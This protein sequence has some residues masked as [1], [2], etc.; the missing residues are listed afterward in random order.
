MSEHLGKY[1]IDGILGKG[2]MGVVYKAF[3]PYIQRVVALKTI[4]KELFGECQMDDLISRLKNE[5]QAA[6]RLNHSNIVMVYDY[7][8]DNELAYIAMEFVEGTT[9]NAMIQAHQ[10]IEIPR[11]KA[12][13]SDLLLALQYA[14]SRGVVH[15]D[16]KPSNL[17]ITSSDRLK[18]S[19]FGVAHL[20]TSTLTEIGSVIGTPSYMSPEQFRGEPL[21]ARSDLFSA[22]IVLYQLL[23]GARPF[24]GSTSA[25]MH[26][27][28]TLTPPPPSHH[29]PSLGNAYDKVVER[30]MAKA[31]DDRYA[32]AIE[33]LRALEAVEDR[34]GPLPADTQPAPVR[35][36]AAAVPERAPDGPGASDPGLLPTGDIDSDS[37]I[38]ADG[39]LTTLAESDRTMLAATPR[40]SPP[41]RQAAPSASVDTGPNLLL[42]SWKQDVLPEVEKLL[43][44]QIGPV[45]KVLAKKSLAKAESLEELC[46]LVLPHIPSQGARIQFEQAIGLLT[47]K[48]AAVGTGSGGS[49]PA[50]S[51]DLE[52]YLPIENGASSSSPKRFEMVD[53]AWESA[54]T[55]QLLVLVGPIARI[56]VKRAGRQTRKRAEFLQVVAEHIDSSAD[57]ALFLANTAGLL[58]R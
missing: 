32:S 47:K 13:M 10:R 18:V 38:L 46:T 53:E 16:I 11:V 42:M 39:S 35:N 3:D 12:W 52:P 55:Q 8:E 22:G 19:D 21:D 28:L 24:S 36:A 25:V 58:A 5:A 37:T 40:I 27:I 2:A 44:Y 6:G 29:L 41:P 7:G 57:R 17:I 45:G 33:F 56:I 9:L 34:A 54:V 48:L 14:H 26:Q 20:D 31:R 1:R 23:C 50:G 30:A 4:R 49:D 51:A 15:R 43:L